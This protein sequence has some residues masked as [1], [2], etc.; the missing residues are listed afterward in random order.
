MWRRGGLSAALIVTGIVLTGLAFAGLT[1]RDSG[2]DD[3]G[4][5]ALAWAR[6]PKVFTPPRLPSDRVLSGRVKNGSLR[7][8]KLVARDLRV[9]D[10]DGRR[11]ESSAIFLESFVHGLYPPTREPRRLPEAE[12]RRIGRIALIDP[13]KT[14]PLTVAWRQPS[15]ERTPVRVDYGSGSLPI[16]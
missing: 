8:V 10:T 1:L 16:P 3:K 13:G 6:G 5:G 2:Q 7:R 14:V 4:S 12:L 9:L 15:G 11:V